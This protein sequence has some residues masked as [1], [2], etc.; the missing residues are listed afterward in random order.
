MRALKELEDISEG[1]LL[2]GLQ[3]EILAL[4]EA[5]KA[6]LDPIWRGKET[7]EGS[8]NP[9]N[10][11]IQ[12]GDKAIECKAYRRYLDKRN[13]LDQVLPR[14]LG[15][16]GPKYLLTR[17]KVTKWVEKYAIYYGIILIQGL[18]EFRDWCR[19]G[20]STIGTISTNPNPIPR[21]LDMSLPLLDPDWQDWQPIEDWGIT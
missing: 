13:F 5:K 21:N 12:V 18:T 16:K 8:H 3:W 17:G 7:Y 14:L 15:W 4:R 19:G 20:Y 9:Y 2:K 10:F 1:S 11:D 6:H